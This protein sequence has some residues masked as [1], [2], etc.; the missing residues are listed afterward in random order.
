M[1]P[2]C[3]E[4]WIALR[5]TFSRKKQ[6]F[7]NIISVIAI[8]GVCLSVGSLIVVNAVMQGFKKAVEEKILGLTPHISITYLNQDETSFLKS[9][10]LKVIPKSQV[11]SI[12]ETASIQGLLIT[13]FTNT[14][15]VLKAI[16]VKDLLKLKGVKFLGLNEKELKFSQSTP[17]PVI[18]GLKLA[19][20]LGIE[21]GDVLRFLSAEGITTPFG[22]FPKVLTLK[23]VGFF[24]TGIYD[25]DY[26]FA[27]APLNTVLK[28]VKPSYFTLEVKLRDPFK[29]HHYD[30]LLSKKLSGA[31]SVMDWQEW[32]RNFFAALKMERLGLF[33]VLTLMI[34]VSLFTI[35]AAMMMLVSEKK[36]DI[37]ILRALGA[38]KGEIL[39][40]FFFCGFFLSL[41]GV[42]LGV[43][44]GSSLCE[45]LARYPIVK[46]PSGVYPVEYM[47]VALYFKDVL[48]ISL[49]AMV[50]SVLACLYPARKAA[51][52]VPVEVLRNG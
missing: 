47:P 43:L 35:V 28:V 5:Y 19:E 1:N 51:D 21:K 4:L 32:N 27:F 41:A 20:R 44:L 6:R 24:S 7:L 2:S 30:E 37:A 45:I 25:F 34:T 36:R 49:V 42:L 3:W 18:I 10:V 17:I 40:V 26:G 14:G 8:V 38:S 29:A 15:V 16:P 9:K 31:F 13:G 11:S 23:V 52:T 46:L 39:K 33:V 50:I 22:F 12:F 48:L